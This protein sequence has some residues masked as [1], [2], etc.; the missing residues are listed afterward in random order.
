MSALPWHF[1]PFLIFWDICYTGRF[2]KRVP[3]FN[4]CSFIFFLFDKGLHVKCNANFWFGSFFR[5]MAVDVHDS[6]CEDV[7]CVVNEFD[8]IWISRINLEIKIRNLVLKNNWLV[9]KRRVD[10]IPVSFMIKLDLVIVLLI[11]VVK[12]RAMAEWLL[13]SARNQRHSKP[14]SMQYPTDPSQSS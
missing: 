4:E 12:L 2:R 8:R 14:F 3:K 10:R 5:K 11:L 13:F 9:K 6:F 7:G 1:V